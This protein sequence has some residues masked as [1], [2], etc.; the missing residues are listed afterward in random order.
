MKGGGY[1]AWK[2][3]NGK[4]DVGKGDN[5]KGDFGRSW[6]D[7]R[8]GPG[9]WRSDRRNGNNDRQ[10]NY[11]GYN[12]SPTSAVDQ[13]VEALESEIKRTLEKYSEKQTK[14]FDLIFEIL[15]SLQSQHSQ[16]E[17]SIRTLSSNYNGGMQMVN[18]GQ[19]WQPADQQWQQWNG[20]NGMHTMQLQPAQQMPVQM[21]PQAQAMPA[22]GQQWQAMP[23]N[24]Q[25]QAVPASMAPM[26][27]T[28]CASSSASNGGGGGCMNAHGSTPT[29]ADT[30]R[31][32]GSGNQVPESAD[33]DQAS[34]DQ[35]IDPDA[36]ITCAEL[37]GT[38]WDKTRIWKVVNL[39]SDDDSGMLNVTTQA[40]PFRPGNA[41]PRN[42]LVAQLKNGDLV[43]QIG[44]SKKVR[45]HMVMPVLLEHVDNVEAEAADREERLA[46]A[47]PEETQRLGWTTRRVVNGQDWLEKV[48]KEDEAADE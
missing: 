38:A 47:T 3:D 14:T 8:Q 39:E 33:R 24:Q 27:A 21:F 30:S 43:R 45:G 28:Q 1:E 13:Q 32:Y 7:Q 31:N 41:P 18:N 46:S 11:N 42:I 44:H 40:Q 36:F 26:G 9:A 20:M 16:L 6:P 34:D 2:G 19:Q 25:W 17:T 15:S 10:Q 5:G 23:N 48:G 29:D 35:P 37:A 4:G 12:E 22:G